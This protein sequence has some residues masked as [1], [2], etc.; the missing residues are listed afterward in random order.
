M[1]PLHEYHEGEEEKV[2]EAPTAE[3]WVDAAIEDVGDGFY[4]QRL[5]V[6]SAALWMSDSMEVSLLSF[7]YQ[8]VGASFSLTSFQAASIV[9]VVFAGEL[10][11]AAVAGPAADAWGRKP[12]SVLAASLVAF[13][14]LATALS[15][16]VITF[17]V[18]RTLVG[19]GVG[20]LAVP[21]DLMAEFLPSSSRGRKLTLLEFAWAGGA[22]YATTASFMLRRFSWRALVLACGLPFV[23]VF[24]GVATLLDESPRWLLDKGKPAKARAVLEKVAKTNGKRLDKLGDAGDSSRSGRSGCSDLARQ[25]AKLA[26]P[27]LRWRTLVVWVVWLGFGLDFYGISLLVTR[28][29]GRQRDDMECSF[30]YGFILV[31][32]TAQFTGTFALLFFIDKL[33]RVGSQAYPYALTALALLPLAFMSR[34]NPGL[35][36]LACLY[37]SLATQMMA[38]SATWIHI[39]ELYPT[40]VRSTA[41]SAALTVSR[42]SAFSASYIVDSKLPLHRVLTVLA[43]AAV[44]AGIAAIHLPET[45]GAALA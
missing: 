2:T 20:A 8:C 15:P 32:T 10:L 17:I 18:C 28:L 19:V 7:L 13:A 31:L 26:S 23:G 6:L 30:R 38:S 25:V 42:L 22:L 21:F 1:N 36:H 24:A 4:Q 43:A 29:F 3:D 11:G 9:S 34:V 41:H 35:I 37:V 39:P 5:M 40:D 45:K 27:E 33:G 14:G 16:D 12:A 44:A